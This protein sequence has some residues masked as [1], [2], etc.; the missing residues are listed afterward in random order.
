MKGLAEVN[1]VQFWEKTPKPRRA[2]PRS[3][4]TTFYE[5]GTMV[6]EHGHVFV[7][8]INPTIPPFRLP[9]LREFPFFRPL[10]PI[11]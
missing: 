1:A 4:G 9:V 5:D 11:P 2:V 6:D 8:P 7:G 10:F 3:R